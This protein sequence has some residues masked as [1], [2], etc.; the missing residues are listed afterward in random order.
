MGRGEASA[1]LDEVFYGPKR[2][3][4]YTSNVHYGCCLAYR[5]SGGPLA[6]LKDTTQGKDKTNFVLCHG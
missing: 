2:F 4:A 6:V 1:L 5:C 3:V